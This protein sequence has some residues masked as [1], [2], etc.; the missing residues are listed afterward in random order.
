MAQVLRHLPPVLDKNVIVG[1]E[2]GDDAA[3]YRLPSGEQLVATLDF[4]TPVVDDARD[5]GRIAAAN[6]LSDVYAMGGRP[7]FALSIVCWPV[8]LGLEQLGQV[9]AG[10]AATTTAAGIPILGGHSVD[11]AVPK[12]GL[13]AIGLVEQGKLTANKGARPG[14][15]LYLTKPLGSGALTG[16]LK[17]GLLNE[18]QT[19]RVIDVMAALNDKAALA[20][21]AA[22]VQAATDVTGFGLLGHLQKMMLASG[23]EALVRVDHLPVIEGAWP[24]YATGSVP[25]GTKRNLAHFGAS[26]E[27]AA[28]L[29]AGSDLLAA[30]AQTSGG[31]LACV[32][33]DGVAAFEATLK[34]HNALVACIGEVRAGAAGKCCFI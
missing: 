11:D 29:P 23:T 10:G 5:F 20:M 9:M 28:S 27:F 14:D 26:A 6:A 24:L 12:Y 30:D 31:I 15:R 32:P 18:Q 16:A 3:V 34:S 22:R 8:K 13:V 1:I 25:G 19:Q 4:F 17:K 21:N 7:L 2:H 33:Q